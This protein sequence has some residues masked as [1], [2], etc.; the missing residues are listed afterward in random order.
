MYKILIKKSALKQIEK[1][2]VKILESI[3]LKI[4][5]LEENPRP[6][7]CK[8]LKNFYGFENIYRIIIRDY[9]IIYTVD[10]SLMIIEIMK[11]GH[12]SNIYN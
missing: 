8:K 6:D 3:N 4:T 5:S 1:L 9:R 2:P 12:R 10:D 11:I 7:G